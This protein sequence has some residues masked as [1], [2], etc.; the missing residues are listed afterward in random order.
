MA[1][2]Q[3]LWARAAAG[4]CGCSAPPLLLLLGWKLRKGA[5]G[6]LW[7]GLGVPTLDARLAARK[8]DAGSGRLLLA[9]RRL[10]GGT[11]CAAEPVYGRISAESLAEHGTALLVCSRLL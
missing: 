9:A 3:G 11:G 7:G 6:P 5:A 2:T 10:A 1:R 4:A 8:A